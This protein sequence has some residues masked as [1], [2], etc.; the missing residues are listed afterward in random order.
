MH[1]CMVSPQYGCVG[2][3]EDPWNEQMHGNIVCIYKDFHL[4]KYDYDYMTVV[5]LSFEIDACLVTGI[6]WQVNS[7]TCSKTI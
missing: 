4:S 6:C 1:T 2:D 5:H 3:V 7:K